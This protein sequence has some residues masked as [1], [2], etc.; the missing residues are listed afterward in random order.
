MSNGY[1][2]YMP[3]CFTCECFNFVLSKMPFEQ[4]AHL[5]ACLTFFI[6]TSTGENSLWIRLAPMY[7]H[8]KDFVNMKVCLIY[9]LALYPR[10]QPWLINPSTSNCN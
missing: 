10:Q 9:Y 5:P 4:Q 3:T 8:L 6:S 1:E 2:S 7:V